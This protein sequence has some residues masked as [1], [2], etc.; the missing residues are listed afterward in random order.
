VFAPASLDALR[1]FSQIGVC[2][3][4]FVGMELNL[5]QLRHSAHRFLVIGHSSILIPY[6]FGVVL[7]LSLYNNY[8]QAGSIS[9]RTRHGHFH[10]HHR[11]SS[12]RPHFAGS[13]TLPFETRPETLCAAIGD[14][15]AWCILAFIVAMRA[16]RTS[17]Q[18]L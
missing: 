14:V 15:T 6:L 17:G 1:L 16:R 11:L 5:S 2:I 8:A 18:H 10:E 9:L 3:F 12:A 13:Q 4:M 7:A